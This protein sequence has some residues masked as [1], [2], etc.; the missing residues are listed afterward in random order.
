VETAGDLGHSGTVL[1]PETDTVS[2]PL[3]G[4]AEAP[5]LQV[6][7]FNLRNAV[8]DG[9][10]PW[11]ERRAAN[12]A[13]LRAEL[14][15]VIGTQEGL[16]QQLRELAEGLPAEYEWIGTGREGGSRGEFMAVFFDASRLEPR[17]FDHFWL[18]DQPDLVG[19][20][21]WGNDV[22]RMATWV[23]FR[24][25]ATGVT[26]VVLN[27]HLDHAV[28]EAQRRGAELVAGRLGE[29]DADLPVLVTGDFNVA[30]EASEPYATLVGK[31][32]L[33]D[34]WTA[35]DERLSPPYATFHGYRPPEVGG[36]RIDWI[37]ARP[38]VRVPVAA[39]NTFTLDGRWASD[40]W[41]VQALVDLPRD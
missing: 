37:L 30:A 22:V 15:T 34:T 9:T 19:S 25:R 10:D 3:V 27:T 7:S 28:D 1:Q 33:V 18:S 12:R 13:L 6:M 5:Y 31:A 8:G 24:D 21:S 11:S 4:R 32:G 35:A 29:F 41:P 17:E 2:T 14:P 20:S 38:G 36:A 23:R 39:I 40:H 26:F 16:Y